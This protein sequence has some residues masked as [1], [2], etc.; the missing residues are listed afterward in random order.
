MPRCS[1]STPVLIAVPPPPSA[2]D[3]QPEYRVPQDPAGAEGSEEGYL[4]ATSSSSS[5][6]EAVAVTSTALALEVN[7][8][9]QQLL[10]Q[11]A[12]S[13]AIQAEEVEVDVDPVVD[14]LAP[15]GP[16]RVA[17]P[18]IRMSGAGICESAND[19]SSKMAKDAII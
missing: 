19:D 6:D 18:L 4:S 13:L 9:L 16:S 10:R 12:Q 2:P 17:L 8:V 3:T 15:L 5:P 7:R 11:A 14:I 1:A